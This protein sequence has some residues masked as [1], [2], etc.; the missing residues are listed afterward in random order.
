[1]RGMNAMN[2]CSENEEMAPPLSAE[3]SVGSVYSC[4]GARPP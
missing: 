1:M 2:G 4:P 3:E